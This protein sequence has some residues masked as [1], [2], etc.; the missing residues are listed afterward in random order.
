MN[1][2][3]EEIVGQALQIPPEDRAIIAEKLISSLDAV[4]DLDVEAAWQMEVQQRIMEADK[5]DVV[6]I[7][8]E[9]VQKRLKGTE[10]V[11]N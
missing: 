2:V 8:W 7:P 11:R 5:G 1:K 10:I 4:T 9:V 6:C 3:A